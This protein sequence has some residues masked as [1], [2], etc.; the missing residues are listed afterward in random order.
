MTNG[1]PCQGSLVIGYLALRK[2]IGILGM[3]LPIAVSF[4]AWVYFGEKIQPT[5]SDYYYTGMRDV[6]VGTLWAIGFFLV[7]Y[8]GYNCG[9]DLA[10]DLACVFAVGASLFP[11][12]QQGETSKSAILIGHIHE[13][14]AFLFFLT[15]I[16]FSLVFFTR[17]DNNQEPTG[18]KLH[19]N[20]VYKVCGYVMSI[21]LALSVVCMVIPDVA[22]FVP[23]GLNPVFWLETITI[24]AFGISWLTKGQ[25]ILKDEA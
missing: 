19:R 3:A 23:K 9:E 8:K 16:I 13:V 1:L 5:I 14:F 18:R 4:G 12:A 10:G 11:T 25:A 2:A 20:R 6:F 17:T 15:L 21:C 22:T 24:E 7:S